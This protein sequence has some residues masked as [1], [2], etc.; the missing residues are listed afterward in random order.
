[1]VRVQCLG[2]TVYDNKQVN[3]INKRDVHSVTVYSVTESKML[4]EVA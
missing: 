4:Y 2:N 3:E 1:V